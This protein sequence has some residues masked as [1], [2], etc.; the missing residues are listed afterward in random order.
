MS[1]SDE[2]NGLLLEREE[3]GVVVELDHRR[4]AGSIDD[5]RDLLALRRRRLAPVPCSVR[6]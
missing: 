4:R 5:P 2:W 6:S 1:S 3:E